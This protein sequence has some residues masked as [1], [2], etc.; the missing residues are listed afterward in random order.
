MPSRK[1]APRPAPSHCSPSAMQSPSPPSTTG[2][3]GTAAATLSRNGKRCQPAMLIGLTDP[4]GRSTGPADAIPTAAIG[5]PAARTTSA[6]RACTTSHTSSAGA[7]LGVG[8]TA[9]WTSVPTEST[10]AAAIL[11]PPMSR[12]RVSMPISADACCR[13]GGGRRDARSRSRAAPARRGVRPATAETPAA[14]P[15][16]ATA[17]GSPVAPRPAAGGPKPLCAKHFGRAAMG[18][19]GAGCGRGRRPAPARRRPPRR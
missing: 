16:R 2:V 15:R 14:A 13:V 6:I 9:V 7:G 4:L 5:A 3:A 11:V 8:R 12:P 18:R 19:T 17:R 1:R 10:S